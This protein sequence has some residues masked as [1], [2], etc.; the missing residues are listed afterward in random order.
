MKNAVAGVLA[1]IGCFGLGVRVAHATPSTTYWTP[2]TLDIQSFGIVHIG[3]DNYFT[4]GTK[5]QDGAAGFPTDAGLTLGVLPFTKL[6]MEIGVDYL[7]PSDAPFYF[8]AKLGA[9]EGALFKGAPAL[10][11][12]IFNVGTKKGVTNQNIG[13]VVVGKSLTVIG[14]VSAGGYLGNG[15]VLRD[16]DGKKANSGVMVALDHAFVTV[17]GK[18]GDEFSRW[19]VAAD[20]ASGKNALGG[21]GFGVYYFFT[22]NVSLLTGPVWFNEER[23]NGKWKW[24]IQLD[25]NH[26][27]IFGRN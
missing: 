9:P 6:Q 13:H 23:I 25:I 20:Y 3:V 7:G 19:V 22:K 16:A 14:R 5:A 8:N 10:Q 12:G 2:M 26:P 27:R 1:L 4:I 17:K 21:G 15:A 24:T 18:D 11:A